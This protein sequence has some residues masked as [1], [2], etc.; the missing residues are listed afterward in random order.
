M[1]ILLIVL[2]VAFAAA[3]GFLA[4]FLELAG[5]FILILAL[6]GIIVGVGVAAAVR[7][8]LGIDKKART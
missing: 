1:T 8:V 5:I 6:I 4:E 7:R 2:L 3:G